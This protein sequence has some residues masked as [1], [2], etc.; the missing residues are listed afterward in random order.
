MYRIIS[1]KT[2]VVEKARL[3]VPASLVMVVHDGVHDCET[4]V[5]SDYKWK[6]C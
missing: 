3:V 1:P 5:L 4:P 6:T 2:L